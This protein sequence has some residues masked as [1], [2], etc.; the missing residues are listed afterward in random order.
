MA[1]VWLGLQLLEQDRSLRAQRELERQ[2]AAGQ[3]VV[4]SLEQALAETE[5]LTG[6]GRGRRP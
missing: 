4:R 1:L 3:S 6:A 2:Q 5:R